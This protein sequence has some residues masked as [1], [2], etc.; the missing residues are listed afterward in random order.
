MID[1]NLL[2]SLP[3]IAD[4]SPSGRLR[5]LHPL[6][7][8]PPEGLNL[9]DPDAVTAVHG[10]FV[11]A[12]ATLLRTNTAA[13]N[14]VLLEPFSL[15][16]RCEAINA[17]AAACV[18]GATLG[19]GLLMGTLGQIDP[20]GPA[21]RPERE[22]AYGE[23]MVYLSDME[24]TFFLLHHFDHLE[25]A[26][27]VL[28]MAQS[29]SDALV[30][31]QLSFDE[32]GMTADGF[33]LEVAGARLM[34]AGAGALGLGCSTGPA[35]ALEMAPTLMGLSPVIS[36]MPGIAGPAARSDPATQNPGAGEMSPE[37]FAQA[38]LPLAGM[39]VAILGGCCGVTPR[40]TAAL[41]RHCAGRG[42]RVRGDA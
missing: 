6:A 2:K 37:E 35:A 17:G 14:P 40:H 41:A 39:G 29:S 21:T 20:R 4:G 36:V 7:P 34:E 19:K 11:Q 42:G 16:E 13:A 25:E 22:R 1:P 27:L 31:A 30:L 32:R 26:L 8:E 9:V 12:G 18:R 38:M 23:Q 5:E 3:V 28:G 15:R 10:E 33:S 24:V